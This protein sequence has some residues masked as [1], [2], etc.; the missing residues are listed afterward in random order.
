MA[1][2]NFTS[3]FNYSFEKQAVTLSGSASQVGSAGVNAFLVHEDITFIAQAMGEE[4]NNITI[5]L[6][7]TGAS[8]P[9]SISVIG[10]AIAI[11]LESTLGVVDTDYAA[12]A[13]AI[14]GDSA[15]SALIRTTGTSSNPVAE[16]AE[17]PLADGADSEFSIIGLQSLS[18]EQIDIGEYEISFMDSYN[19]MLCPVIVVQKAISAVAIPQVVSVDV[20]FNG[21]RSMIF[22]I[23][24][25]SGENID[26]EDGD[27]MYFNLLLRNN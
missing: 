18:L 5:E 20:S 25:E 11:T 26:L 13:A 16:L 8:N 27:V 14:L 23:M 24:D 22:R 10:T 4:G 2:R 15:A 12:L 17:T 21:S 1:N 9:L 3:Q 6:I 19:A 7:N